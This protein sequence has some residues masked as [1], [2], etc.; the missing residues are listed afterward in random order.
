MRSLIESLGGAS[1]VHDRSAEPAVFAPILPIELQDQHDY[2]ELLSGN[3]Q[4]SIMGLAIYNESSLLGLPTNLSGLCRLCLADTKDP[5][6]LLNQIS[7]GFDV[8]APLFIQQ[9]TDAGICL[10]FMFPAP[11]ASR[12]SKEALGRDMWSAEHAT[13]MEPLQDKCTCY[14]CRRHNRAYV[15]HLL[16]AKEMLAWILLQIHNLQVVDTFFTGIRSSIARGRFQEDR[17]KFRE[18]YESG[19]PVKTGLGPR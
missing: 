7:S 18:F 14:A 16:N 12:A 10:D 13:D 3:A 15:Q 8:L 11:K 19:L 5:H 2:L 17:Q 9:A 6:E 1:A 4:N